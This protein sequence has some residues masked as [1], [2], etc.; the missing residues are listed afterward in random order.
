MSAQLLPQGALFPGLLCFFL[1][2]IYFCLVANKLTAYESVFSCVVIALA[3]RGASIPQGQ[4][5]S[6]CSGWCHW[7]IAPLAVNTTTF[8]FIAAVPWHFGVCLSK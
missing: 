1:H 7:L 5:L 6:I 8:I 2:T 4:G 3:P